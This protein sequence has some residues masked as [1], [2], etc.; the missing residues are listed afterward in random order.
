MWPK[1]SSRRFFSAAR[2]LFV[3]LL[4][5]SLAFPV[6]VRA[7]ADIPT[8][9]VTKS[10]NGIYIVWMADRPVVSYSG[11][12]AGFRATAVAAGQRLDP[13]RVEVQQYAN[14]L[15]DQQNAALAPVG[16]QILVHYRYTFNGFAARLTSAEA[17]ALAGQP[18]V[19]R[20][21]PD[22]LVSVDT[23]STPEYLGLTQPGGLWDQLG[24]PTNA[25]RGVIVGIIDSGLWPESASFADDGSFSRPGPRW[26]GVCVSGE[27][28]D[29]ATH[30]S[31]KV[32][33]ARYYNAGWGGDA[34]L[35]AQLP[36]EFN[37]P[38]DYNGHGSHTASTA[39]GNYNVPAAAEGID[40]GLASGMA[41]AAHIAVYKAC[42]SV[43]GTA[44]SCF[45]VDLVSAIEDATTD[46]VDVINFS[47]SGSRNNYVEAVQFAFLQ[48]AAAGVF[49][50]ASAGNNGPGASTVAHISP[51]VTSVAAGTHNRDYVSSVTL[52][53]GASYPG[54]SLS[55]GT[56]SLP[57]ILS[58]AAGLPGADANAVRLC[59]AAVDN[60]GVPVLDPAKVAGQIVLCDRGVNARVNKS[61]AVKEAGGLGVILANT[62]PN[63]LNADLHFIP[64]IHV[65]EVVGAQIKAYV[66]TPGGSPT[67]QIAPGVR[68]V[69]EAPAVAAFSSRGPSLAGG[70]DLL[71]PD[72]LAPGVDV[73]AVVAPPNNSGRDFDFYSG[74]SMASPHIAGLAA[75]LKARFVTW[76]PMMIKSALMTTASQSTNFGNPI[77][78]NPFGYGA[79]QARPSLAA[80]PG[81]VYNSSAADWVAFLCG[82]RLLTDPRCPLVAIDASDLNYPS[83]AIGDLAG[84]QTVRRTVMHVGGRRATYTASI[85]GLAGITAEVS[86]SV[87]TFRGGESKPFT[88]KF[89]RTTAP[90]NAYT[91]GALVWSD[92]V[93]T[94]R[95]PIAIRPV[96]LA[97]PAQVSGSY[98]V[99]FGYDGPFGATAR[100]L[101]AATTIE[102]TVLDDPTNSA[103]SL[104]SPNAQ[105]IPVSVPAGVTYARFSLF[106]EFTDG[107]DDLDMCVFR[108]ATLVGLSGTSTS[109]EEVNLLNPPAATYTVVVQGWGTDGPD[110]QFTLFYWL[111]GS[112]SAGNM[113]VTAPTVATTGGVGTITLSFSGLTP[114]VKY[115]GSV[116]YDGVAGLPNPTIVRVD[117]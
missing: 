99:T 44:G 27:E 13:T 17:E 48:A 116:A 7:A 59:F 115:L 12:I 77:P 81:L 110:A 5:L 104:T 95:S 58:T 61:L 2:L 82:Q 18:G 91:F 114:G 55:D 84:V 68:S 32:V 42:Y 4:A 70:G 112:T 67:A 38:R 94:V 20:V 30:C 39:A 85:E 50:A 106:D 51:W 63:S 31:N 57:V 56:P 108:G 72:I 105:L 86:P 65:D 83:I 89:T 29:P 37:S 21:E 6:T 71:K 117:P 96:A 41:P 54:K 40:L 53:N 26:R 52:G 1:D 97:A 78:G 14:Y 64:T 46:G 8:G 24:G 35:K 3:A 69:G 34:G 103:C 10:P 22:Q 88:V 113:T 25:G 79:G 47:I 28:W 19:L 80:N 62:S 16:G 45:T 76:T 33:G 102:A 74:T 11:G 111:L 75:L 9:E 36:F 49:V 15:V 90:V 23:I 98:N 60:G 66:A 43:P 100:G 92:G 109:A 93:H 101:V 87:L 107:A 73:L